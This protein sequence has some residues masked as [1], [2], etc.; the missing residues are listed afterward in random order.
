MVAF[1]KSLVL[2]SNNSSF[3]NSF[4]LDCQNVK[5]APE[6]ATLFVLKKT[7][8]VRK[9]PNLIRGLG[10]LISL[11]FM[12]FSTCKSQL[13][14]NFKIEKLLFRIYFFWQICWSTFCKIWLDFLGGLIFCNVVWKFQDISVNHIFREINFR[15]SRNSKTAVFAIFGALNFANLVY[16]S[17]QKMQN[18]IK[19]KFQS[20][21]NCWNGRF[22][23]SRFHK[24]N[25]T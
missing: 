22:C 17:L 24:I 14:G 16:L 4:L 8:S 7:L 18:F 12:G 9:I 25:F 13:H 21:Q 2:L 5:K 10:A 1:S 11:H 19:I 6:L 23:I 15:D 3:I 20:L